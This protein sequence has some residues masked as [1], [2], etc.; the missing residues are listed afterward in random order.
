MTVPFFNP[1][2][3]AARVLDSFD[4]ADNSSS[5]GNADT[6]QAWTAAAGTWG[7][8]GNLGY[9]SA[10]VSN[11]L[12]IVDSTL[13]DATVQ[14]TLSTAASIAGLALRFSSLGND[15]RFIAVSGNSFLLQR[16]VGAAYTTVAS[17]SQTVNNGDVMKAV[18]SGTGFTCYVN[19]VQVF[20]ASDSTY[21]TATKHGLHTSPLTP[22]FN[23]FSVL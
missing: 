9:K 5:L 19:G 22:R 3:F 12:A 10:G 13:A 23:D 20:T 11:D 7:V 21:Q 2:R 15:W 4:R 16:G 17:I 8:L 6:G 18:M 1:Y 14:V